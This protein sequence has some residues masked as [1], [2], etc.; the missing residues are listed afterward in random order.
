MRPILRVLVVLMAGASLI[1][2]LP[3]HTSSATAASP[4]AATVNL[5]INSLW[6]IQNLPELPTIIKQFEKLHPNV[7]VTWT[8]NPA[9]K[10]GVAQLNAS[11]LS[12]NAP[13]VIQTFKEDLNVYYQA[14]Y[15]TDLT[16]WAKS[17]GIYYNY[18]LPGA[19]SYVSPLAQAMNP[20]P[21]VYGVDDLMDVSGFFYNVGLF[22][23]YSLQ[24]PT[25]LAQ[26]MNVGKVFLAHGI[27][28]IAI[29]AGTNDGNDTDILA[30]IVTQYV[31]AGEF[32]KL[33]AGAAKYTDPQ[34][35]AAAKVVAQLVSAGIIGADENG[36]A[37]LVAQG[38]AAMCSMHSGLIPA[39][40]ALEK[41]DPSFKLGFITGLKFT[42]HPVSL[43]AVT[44]GGVW[45]IP[46]SDKPSVLPIAEDFLKYLTSPGPASL[47]ANAVGAPSDTLAADKLLTGS[48][49]KAMFQNVE[50]TVSPQSVYMLD[51][52]PP[53]VADALSLGIQKLLL[54]EITSQG[55]MQQAQAAQDKLLAQ[56][57]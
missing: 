6:G 35:M 49:Q 55:M 40:Q 57:S 54:G 4:K 11:L 50:P 18:F 14:G 52:I 48:L 24:P 17:A 45:V 36:C 39:F 46:Y 22:Q 16:S 8:T 28:P 27:T 12:G 47:E 7:H 9:G 32:L 53:Q 25:N 19:Q 3:Y 37:T 43:N 33:D 44:Y 26:L 13:D 21:E 56:K 10:A 1:S 29:G 30:K 20:H 5:T 23:R 15:L 38:K 41:A 42:S 34:M 2:F 31:G 51:F